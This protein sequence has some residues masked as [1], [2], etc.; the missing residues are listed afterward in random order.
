MSRMAQH[1]SLIKALYAAAINAADPVSAV[2]RSL[3][4]RGNTLTVGARSL[5]LTG[6]VVVV[7]IG[8]AAARMATGAASA[9]G[10]KAEQGI[11]I[12]KY[13]HAEG[14]LDRRFMV[15]EA[16]HPIPDNAGAAATREMLDLI[17]SLNPED[18]VLA[19][20]SGGGSALCEA[21]L[22]PVTLDDMAD[23]TGKLLSAGAPIQDL[24]AVRVPL[25]SVKGGKL[26][27][28]SPAG[29]FVTLLLSDVLGNSPEVIASGPTVA[30]RFSRTGAR[31]MVLRYVTWED[32]P[33]NI[34]C[35]LNQNEEV[36]PQHLFEGDVVEVIADNGIAVDSAA[37]EAATRNWLVQ[38]AWR[39]AEGEARQLGRKWARMI[40]ETS[41]VDL[42]IGGG[43][44][45]VTVQGDGQGGRNT[46]FA[47]AAAI[48]L[49]RLKLENWV[50]ASLATDGQ[51]ALTESAGAIVSSGTARKLR[52]A[53]LDAEAMLD[54]ND[55]ATALLAAGDLF[56]PGPTGTNVNDLFFAVR[57]D[58]NRRN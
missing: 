56:S 22:P 42:L 33:V 2:E 21:P 16:G 54:Q 45:T 8:K 58:E 24:N 3:A 51:D 18:I 52:G 20:I 23:L 48:E 1:R 55:S 37:A 46:E 49:E 9:L 12:T 30:S 19:L 40:A 32:V 38:V 36:L 7:S 6:R 25:S 4:L 10:D 28:A 57:V 15:R 41:D 27:A 13:G 50:V 14:A 17:T 53:G 29:H 44:A 39:N 35:L 47:L 31:D 43:E 5:E 26:R 34:R 11:V